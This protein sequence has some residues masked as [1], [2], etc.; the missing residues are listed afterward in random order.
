L[1]AKISQVRTEKYHNNLC[2]FFQ[3]LLLSDL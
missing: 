2:D 3:F 1:T